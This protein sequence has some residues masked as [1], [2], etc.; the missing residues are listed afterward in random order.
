MLFRSATGPT[1][2]TSVNE[3]VATS[4]GASLAITTNVQVRP[5]STADARALCELTLDGVV[6]DLQDVTVP[7]GVSTT[8][9]QTITTVGTETA[10]GPGLVRLQCS[11][12]DPDVTFSDVRIQAI[13]VD[14][15]N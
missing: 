5:D 11:A 9:G 1:G 12:N 6:L 10:T 14:A 3:T 8:G 2:A 7:P 15:F 4:A 13:E